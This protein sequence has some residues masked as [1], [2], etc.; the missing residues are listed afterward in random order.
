M[1]WSYPDNPGIQKISHFVQH[2]LNLASDELEVIDQ[3][4]PTHFRRIKTAKEWGVRVERGC[5][6]SFM[7]EFYILHSL[8][9]RRMGVPVQPWKFFKLLAQNITQ[10]GL[11]F[12]LLAYK[13]QKC[14]AGAV[15][16]NW[17][18]T[19]VYKYSASIEIARQMHATDYLLWT[20]ILWGCE[21]GYSQMDFGRTETDNAGL[22]TFKN[23]WGAEETPLIYS[24]ISGEPLKSS[25]GRMQNLSQMIIRNSPLLVCRLAGELLYRYFG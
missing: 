13:D 12:I 10:K 9:R 15:F 14:I 3:I 6:I 4:K 11:G 2:R 22:R 17:N 1:R 18:N 21:N 7:K 19:L 25:S 20:A 8:T 16:L 23:C 5:D 24:V